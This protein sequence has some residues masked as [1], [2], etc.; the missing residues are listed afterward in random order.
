MRTPPKVGTTHETTFKVEQ[1]H[2]V[3]LAGGKLPAVLSTPSL[4][5]FLEHTALDLMKPYLDEGEITVGIKVE[6]EHLAP[7]PVAL[8]VT[9]VARVVH[10][11]GPVVSFQIEGRD[12]QE[13]IAKGLHKRRAV[14]IDRIRKRVEQK[15]E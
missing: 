6:L 12:P 8:K 11:D 7:T 10:T 4:V 14:R 1:S 15:R 2:T 5:W 3:E 13:L 9:C